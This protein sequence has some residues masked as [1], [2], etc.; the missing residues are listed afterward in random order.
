MKKKKKKVD[1]EFETESLNEVNARHRSWDLGAWPCDP[2]RLPD[3]PIEYDHFTVTPI[4]FT[5]PVDV[6]AFK[7]LPEL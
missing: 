1:D 3:K 2:H 6:D 5:T 4:K 7:G